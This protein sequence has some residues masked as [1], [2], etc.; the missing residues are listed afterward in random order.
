MVTTVPLKSSL[1]AAWA[2]ERDSIL[3]SLLSMF[4]SSFQPLVSSLGILPGGV[5][6][7]H[8]GATVSVFSLDASA[9]KL[10]EVL[11]SNPPC[12]GSS[13]ASSSSTGV[14]R[15]SWAIL[16][17]FVASSFDCAILQQSGKKNYYQRGDQAW[18]LINRAIG[19][20]SGA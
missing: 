3:S 19:H 12:K 20:Q 6:S 11:A 9:N 1:L 18:L 15:P 10:L 7:G 5:G 16:A 13:L 4:A 8:G 2:D 17:E 14:G